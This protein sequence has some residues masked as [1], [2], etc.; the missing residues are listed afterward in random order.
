MLHLSWKYAPPKSTVTI[1][2]K[3]IKWVQH[4]GCDPVLIVFSKSSTWQ[5][6]CS[7][8][9]LVE[10]LK[11]YI[12]NEFSWSFL[13]PTAVGILAELRVEYYPKNVESFKVRE[14]ELNEIYLELRQVLEVDL[15]RRSTFQC[16]VRSK[17]QADW[18]KLYHLRIGSDSVGQSNNWYS[19]TEVVDLGNRKVAGCQRRKVHLHRECFQDPLSWLNINPTKKNKISVLICHFT[20]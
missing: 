8:L 3:E 18:R 1:N 19:G 9:T 17:F 5:S 11:F 4:L 2:S 16:L 6:S 13:F 14:L 20:S 12:L 7:H 15:K 10:Y